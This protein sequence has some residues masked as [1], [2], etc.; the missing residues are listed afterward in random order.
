MKVLAYNLDQTNLSYE[1][2]LEEK[3][4]IIQEWENFVKLNHNIAAPSPLTAVIKVDRKRLSYI[5]EIF[6]F[7]TNK[8]DEVL[9][10]YSNKQSLNRSNSNGRKVSDSTKSNSNKKFNSTRGNKV[11]DNLILDNS[12]DNDIK[13]II[14][15]LNEEKISH[16]CSYKMKTHNSNKGR[17]KTSNKVYMNKNTF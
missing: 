1:N 9:P 5:E 4:L 15:N 10:D 8:L 12:S 6:Q 17:M 3:K 7:T 14:K 16:R 11:V 2:T 13:K